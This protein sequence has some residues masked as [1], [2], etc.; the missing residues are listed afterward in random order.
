M[1]LKLKVIAPD[2]VVF[3]SEVDE[4]LLPS[5]TGLLGIL[6]N[7]A[8]LL[9][10]LNI[11]VLQVR[12]QNQM[13]NLAIDKGFAEVENNEVTVLVGR[14]ELG[15]QIDLGQAR[16]AKSRAEQLLTTNLA[17]SELMRAQSDLQ[18]ADAQ[19]RAAGG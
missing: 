4:V 3:D 10:G 11:G 19:I 13:V 2:K 16:E 1:V 8:P 5:Q 17:G 6:T 12:M 18:R 7:H 9:T 14:A 15:D